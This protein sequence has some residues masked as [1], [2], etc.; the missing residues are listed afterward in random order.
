[1]W[2]EVGMTGRGVRATA[3]DE[4]AA[5][6]VAGQGVVSM[7]DYGVLL[8]VLGGGAGLSERTVRAVVLRQE[9]LGLVRRERVFAVGPSLVVAT[10]VAASLAG[11]PGTWA[12]LPGLGELRHSLEVSRVAIGLWGRGRWVPERLVEVPAG[13]H[14]PD[15]ELHT[16]RGVVAVEVELVAKSRERTEAAMVDLL[17]RYRW[18][19]YRVGDAAVG[20]HVAS[21]ARDLL[22]G[23]AARVLV[24]G[25]RL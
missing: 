12:G 6:F 11:V 24:D 1:M 4:A 2:V 14:R 21:V 15:G 19:D 3:R 23:D 5:V 20:R 17:E 10:R 9:L 25:Q 7:D 18:L 13:C 22:A 16:S 8:A